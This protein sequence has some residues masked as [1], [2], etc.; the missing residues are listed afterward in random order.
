MSQSRARRGR[1][2]PHLKRGSIAVAVAAIAAA[3]LGAAPAQS[4]TDASCPSAYPVDSLA[5]GQAVTGLTVSSGTTPD[6]FTGNVLG[7][8]KDGIAPGIDMI[9]VRLTNPEI[10]RVGGIWEGM[11]G[12]PV[13]AADGSLIGAVSYGLALGPSPVAGVTPAA[14]MQKLLDA[15]PAAGTAGQPGSTVALP[16]AMRQRIVSSD[17]ATAAEADSGMSQRKTPVAGTGLRSRRS[18]PTR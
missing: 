9:M 8:L 5:K 16:P 10:D 4:A 7:V 6:Q 13:Y 18:K 2:V 14:D 12:S 1:A 15:T 11:S 3:G 17:A